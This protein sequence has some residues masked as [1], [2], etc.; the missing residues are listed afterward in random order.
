LLA[1][2]TLD[3]T[4]MNDGREMTLARRGDEHSIRI[5]GGVL[6]T[7]KSHG[8]EEKLAERGCAGLDA[9]PRARVLV[10]GLGMGFTTRA[11]LAALRPDAIVDV[12]E[13]VSA[14]V[15]WNR[16]LIGHLAD[17]PLLDPR[18]RVIEGDVADVIR[19]ARERYDAI[20]LDVDNGPEAFTSRDNEHLYSREGLRRARRALRQN[21]VVAIWSTFDSRAFTAR[22][23]EADL[24]TRLVRVRASGHSKGVHSLWLGRRTRA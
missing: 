2:R 13:L 1:W 7:S 19:A 22:L 10:G 18:V 12:V 23:R 16:E 8:S 4:L 15:R 5:G 3:R 9:V 11:A 21:G 20:L 24:E 17:A 14:V 6:M